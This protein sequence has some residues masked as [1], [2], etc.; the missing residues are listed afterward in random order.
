MEKKIAS[1][2]F[3]ASFLYCMVINKF[4]LTL[5]AAKN[6]DSL[7]CLRILILN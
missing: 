5:E 7:D 4:S 3:T 6:L 1:S 2:Y